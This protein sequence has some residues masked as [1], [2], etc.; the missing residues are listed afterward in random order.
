MIFNDKLCLRVFASHLTGLVNESSLKSGLIDRKK[1]ARV[2]NCLG[3]TMRGSETAAPI[4]AK[5]KRGAII[6]DRL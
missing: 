5:E 6:D 2:E 1:R 4:L 3:T